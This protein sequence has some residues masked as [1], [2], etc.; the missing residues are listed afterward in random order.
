M[1]NPN[2]NLT[3]TPNVERLLGALRRRLRGTVFFYGVGTVVG[4]VAAWLVFSYLADWGLRVPKFGR[5]FNGLIL[6]G[7]FSAFLWRDLIRPLRRIPGRAGLAILFERSH[8]E[9]R[10]LLVSAVQFQGANRTEAGNPALIE[11]VLRDANE[12]AGGLSVKGILD[13]RPGRVRLVLGTGAALVV[14]L[15]AFA[16]PTHT[17]IFLNRMV[18]GSMLWPQRTHL[19]L[20]VPALDAIARVIDTEELLALRIA[21]GTDVPIVIRAAGEVPDDVRLHFE[22]GRDL[23]LTRSGKN[24]FRTLLRSCQDDVALYATGGDD[25]DGLPRIEVEVL[26][27]PDVGGIAVAVQPPAYSGLPNE[28]LFDRD[29]DVLA[30][31]QLRVHVLPLPSDA[32]GSVRLLPTDV[33]V[34]LASLPFPARAGDANEDASAAD[35]GAGL[36]FDHTAVSSIGFRVELTDD[37]GLTNPDPGLFRIQVVEDRAPTIDMIAPSRSEFEIVLGGAI[38]LRARVSDDFGVE[39]FAWRAEITSLDN[40]RVEVA[41]GTCAL[42]AIVDPAAAG[43]SP[44]DRRTFLATTRLEVNDLATPE[45]PITVDERYL[46]E[47]V[48]TDNRAPEPNVGRSLPIRARV[49]T[50]EELLRRMQERLAR[51]RLDTLSLSNLQTEKRQRVEDLIEALDG[52]GVADAGEAVAIAAVLSGQRRVLGDAQALARDLAAVAEDILYARLDEKAGALLDRY[53]ALASTNSDLRFRQAPW[54]A[55]AAT[56]SEPGATGFALNLV[57]LVGLAIEISE[58]NVRLA[59]SAL[60]EAERALETGV[61]VDALVRASELQSASLVRIDALLDELA[62]WDNFQNIL[63][64]TRDI[65]NRQKALR[66]RTQKFATEK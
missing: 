56:A 63:S 24:V 43:D 41:S 2:S 54:R 4:I 48:A 36:Y 40:D 52:D 28:V 32:T 51:A 37:S 53:D 66:E 1:S 25:E 29:V 61:R 14:A 15:F 3:S 13:E 59:A 20:E 33:A 5:I 22:G 26:Q 57:Q 23:L 39:Q 17:E 18:G 47:L 49:V 65:L 27:P 8:P 35:P 60:D 50:P 30:G 46:F 58:D 55:L 6:L 31:S 9:L 19:T 11:H 42:N 21:R 64:L 38:P 45:I 16:N 62:E 12:R 44:S 7:L 34:P 10:E